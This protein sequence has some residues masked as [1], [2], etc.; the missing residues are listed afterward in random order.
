MYSSEDIINY[1][2]PRWNELPDIELY[3]DQVV[4]LI[5]K[6]TAV[7]AENEEEKIITRTMINNYVKQKKIA[8]PKNKKYTRNHL[9]YFLVVGLLKKFMSLSE[10]AQGILIIRSQ[11]NIERAYD[12]FCEGFENSIKSVFT[13]KEIIPM[14]ELSPDIALIQ[15]VTM[16]YAN[17]LYAKNLINIYNNEN[18]TEKDGKPLKQ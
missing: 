6:H 12:L 11:H 1:H 9:A 10:I 17:M 5:D 15:A 16:S 3:M 13:K 18:E 14:Q 8:P 2:C 7:F 4:S